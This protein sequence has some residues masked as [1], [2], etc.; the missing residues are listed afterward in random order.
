MSLSRIQHS[1]YHLK[2]SRM[3]WVWSLSRALRGFTLVIRD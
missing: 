3:M 1:M 2:E